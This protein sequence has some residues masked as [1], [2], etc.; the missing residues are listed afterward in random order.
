MSFIHSLVFAPSRLSRDQER[1]RWDGEFPI[2]KETI[3][4]Y[5]ISIPVLR[6]DN[7][8]DPYVK[9]SWR[10]FTFTDLLCKR[11]GKTLK[12]PVLGVEGNRIE[13]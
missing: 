6:S 12:G 5:G 4:V 1:I 8:L 10:L 7:N 3:C 13:P 2:L 11:S 9:V